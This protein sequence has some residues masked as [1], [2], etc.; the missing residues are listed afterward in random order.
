MNPAV[1]NQ[2]WTQSEEWYVTEDSSWQGNGRKDPWGR[3]MAHC[4]L[5]RHR[6]SEGEVTH[7][8]TFTTINGRVI[9]LRIFNT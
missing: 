6:N 2:V 7:W 9:P 3:S 4:G 1:R 5:Q 8:T